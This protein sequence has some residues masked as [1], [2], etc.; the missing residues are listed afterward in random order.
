LN[1]ELFIL[2]LLSFTWVSQVDL[3]YEL[4]HEVLVELFTELAR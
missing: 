2:V 3:L 1:L 4:S